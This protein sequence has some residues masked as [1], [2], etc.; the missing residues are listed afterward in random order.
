MNKIGIVFRDCEIDISNELLK[1]SRGCLCGRFNSFDEIIHS[2]T[3]E[4]C[5]LT[6]TKN[7]QELLEKNFIESSRNTFDDVL[8]S[9]S[10][11]NS[12]DVWLVNKRN[13]IC[14]KETF[15]H[16]AADACFYG[17]ITGDFDLYQQILSEEF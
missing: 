13:K 12:I 15:L 16:R 4:I 2:L 1:I 8:S 9:A 6:F 5:F 17:A 3:S 11:F 7:I 10:K 14:N